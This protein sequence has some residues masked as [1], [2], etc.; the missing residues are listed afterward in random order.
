MWY[1]IMAALESRYIRTQV[2]V[3][4]QLKMGAEAKCGSCVQ[5]ESLSGNGFGE[6]RVRLLASGSEGRGSLLWLK[7][8][9]ILQK[10]LSKCSFYSVLQPLV[11]LYTI[12]PLPILRIVLIRFTL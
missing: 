5:S 2:L 3:A 12:P 6:E 10:S 7:C 8:F 4:L 1:L 11:V 9:L